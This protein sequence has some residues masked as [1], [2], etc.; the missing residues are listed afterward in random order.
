MSMS[1]YDHAALRRCGRGRATPTPPL[2]SS[3]AGRPL[4]DQA[5]RLF[6]APGRGRALQTRWRGYPNG[7]EPEAVKVKDMMAVP[8]APGGDAKHCIPRAPVVAHEFLTTL[9]RLPRLVQSYPAG[10][11]LLHCIDQTINSAT[12]IL[13]TERSITVQFPLSPPSVC[14]STHGS[15]SVLS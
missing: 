8:V 1:V 14:S 3:P 6:N 10:H 11:G 5:A 15:Y 7:G 4:A 12:L 13:Q 2:A 9:T